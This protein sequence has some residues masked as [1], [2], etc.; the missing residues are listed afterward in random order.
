VTAPNAPWNGTLRWN[1]VAWCQS[2]SPAT[3]GTTAEARASRAD[4]HAIGRAMRVAART[5]TRFT[6]QKASTMV[7]ASAGTGAQGRYH[8]CRAEADR[9]A[10]SPQVGT[11]PHQ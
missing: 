1:E 8:S 4:R 2:T 9:M 7:T 3:T 10:V 6:T 11:Q 5:E